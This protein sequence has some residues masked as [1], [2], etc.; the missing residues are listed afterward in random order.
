VQEKPSE[1]RSG[2]SP[3]VDTIVLKGLALEPRDRHLTA[4]QLGE[5]L[6][7]ALSAVA[8]HA[9]TARSLLSTEVIGTAP[10]PMGSMPTVVPQPTA[11]PHQPTAARVT[12][13]ARAAGPPEAPRPLPARPGPSPGIPLP[14]LAIGGV[15]LVAMIVVAVLMLR[16][17]A[18]P[19]ATPTA[20]AGTPTPPPAPA[21]AGPQLAYYLTVQ[22]YQD[23][24]PHRDP[25]RLSK[26]MLFGPQ[27]RLRVSVASEQP[28]FLYIVNEGPGPA[29]GITYNVLHP[30]ATVDGGSAALSPGGEVHIPS[31]QSYFALDE[32]QGTE[33][34]WFVFASEQVPELEAV[35]GAANPQDRGVIKD[36]AR[37]E[38]LRAF[39]DRHRA[40]APERTQ[41]DGARRTVLRSSK[42]VLVSA[43]KLEHS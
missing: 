18:A 39:L 16:K 10:Q 13:P 29:G 2:L 8:S 38:G 28:G 12:P 26:E 20:A 23:G 30:K 19:E 5:E 3:L 6:F 42:P 37:L 27:D 14:Y 32:A 35:K 36:P 15:V 9:P 4:R 17:P 21:A 33:T 41:D 43:L 34:M 24:K 7:A 25:F 1:L 11:I 31:A 40:Q 22:R